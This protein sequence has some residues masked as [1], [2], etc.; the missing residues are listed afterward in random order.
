MAHVNRKRERERERE[1]GVLIIAQSRCIRTKQTQNKT[2]SL[3]RKREGINLTH[4]PCPWES[5][6]ECQLLVSRINR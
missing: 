5:M 3:A 2:L 4:S 6:L 1:R